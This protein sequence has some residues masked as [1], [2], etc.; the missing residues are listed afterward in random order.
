[1]LVRMLGRSTWQASAW[2]L[3]A[4]GLLMLLFLL[5][6]RSG[7]T[8]LAQ[9]EPAADAAARAYLPLVQAAPAVDVIQAASVGCNGESNAMAVVNSATVQSTAADPNL[10][11]N[12]GQVCVNKLIP[13][14]PTNTPVAPT[15]TPIAPTPTRTPTNTPTSTPTTGTA[16]LGNRVW[17]DANRN[18]IL[19]TGEVGVPGVTIALVSGC[20]GTTVLGSRTS[21]ANGYFGFA[22]LAPGQYRLQVSNLPAGF[23]FSPQNQGTNEAADSDANPAT[24]ITDCVTLSAGQTENR[25]DTGIYL[26]TAPTATPTNTPVGPTPTPTRTPGGT[27]AQLGNRIWFDA[28]RNGILDTGETGAAGVTITLLSGCSGTTVLGSRTSD[29]NGYYGFANLPPGQYRIRVSN[30]PAGYIFSPQNQGANEAADSDVNPTTGISDCITL[31]AGQVDNRWDAGIMPWAAQT[32]TIGDRVWLDS[33]GDGRQSSG[34]GGVPNITVNL[35]SSCTGTQILASVNTNSSGLYSFSN[36]AAGQYRLQINLPAGV[37]FS[38]L[39]QGADDAS[40]SDVNPASSLSDCITLGAGQSDSRWDVGLK[41]SQ[42]PGTAAV[43]DRVWEDLNHDG[44]QDSGEPGLPDAKVGL[45]RDG[46]LLL[47]QLADAGGNFLF[48]NLAPGNYYLCFQQPATPIFYGL[49][50]PLQGGNPA[51]DSDADPVN[52]CTAPFTL[53]AGQLDRTR[54][55]GFFDPPVSL[56]QKLQAATVSDPEI[57]DYLALN[58]AVTVD[59]DAGAEATDGVTVDIEIGVG[60]AHRLYLPLAAQE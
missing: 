53:N 3:A 45:Y 57:D 11:N 38:P 46:V 51:L 40:D 60:G 43:G 44:L 5:L 22:N 34:E 39:N 25:W 24:G 47:A 13:P 26:A 31:V 17:N 12:T 56:A 2:L 32:A 30:L 42:G 10:F 6:W 33:N 1:M 8:A 41:T 21:D 19:D 7:P 28:N 35:L 20:S 54:D 55:A 9:Q 52:G 58:G 4:A 59:P 48:P 16:Q 14:T 18:G 50:I 23:V 15:N 49:T 36:L 27:T 29:A 37:T